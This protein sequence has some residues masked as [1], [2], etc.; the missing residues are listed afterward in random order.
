[1]RRTQSLT[2]T[3]KNVVV[4]AAIH[5]EDVLG[6][7]EKTYPQPNLSKGRYHLHQHEAV[8]DWAFFSGHLNHGREMPLLVTAGD[9]APKEHWLDSL[10]ILDCFMSEIVCKGNG[11]RDGISIQLPVAAKPRYKMTKQ[12]VDPNDPHGRFIWWIERVLVGEELAKAE[13][14]RG[15]A[16]LWR[17]TDQAKQIQ[18]SGG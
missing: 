18:S 9:I 13:L 2:P 6:K 15:F 10:I 12:P 14:V 3:D 16:A 7:I 17:T 4:M 11:P 1:M 5:Y 8:G